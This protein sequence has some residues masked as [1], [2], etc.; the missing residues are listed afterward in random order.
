MPIP[1][2]KSDF[3]RKGP[4]P[5]IPKFVKS[6]KSEKSETDKLVEIWDHPGQETLT[7]GR[8]WFDGLPRV[9]ICMRK[10]NE[11]LVVKS[12]KKAGFSVKV[13]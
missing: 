13:A 4:A 12:L 3:G 8:I 7:L 11:I 1:K 9:D 10:C 5:A 2:R 6:E